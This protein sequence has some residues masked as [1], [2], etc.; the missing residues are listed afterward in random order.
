MTTS[1]HSHKAWT[2]NGGHVTSAGLCLS[3]LT[4]TACMAHPSRDDQMGSG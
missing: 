4:L 1:T 3:Q 2:D